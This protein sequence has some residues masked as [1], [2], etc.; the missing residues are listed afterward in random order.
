MA[1]KLSVSLDKVEQ[2]VDL[3]TSLEP[4]PARNYRPIDPSIYIEPDI[5]V[6]KD[7][8]GQYII[9]TNKKGLPTL[10]ISQ[11]YRN[12]LNQAKISKEDRA[13]IKEKVNN[14]LNFIRSLQQRGA[15][16]TAIGKYILERQKNF[17][18]DGDETLAPMT[19]K[20]AAEHLQRNESTIS[21][22]IS[23]KYMDTP[24]GLYPLKF[25]FSH[26]VSRRTDENVS[27]H[28]VEQELA[29]LIEEENKL[30]PLSDQD[31]QKHFDAKGLHLAR[32]TITKYRQKLHIPSSHQRK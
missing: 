9:E 31:I 26:N 10:R 1:K 13:F 4:K 19:L 25:F 29:Q 8:E 15:T 28:T 11:M 24:Q 22:A 21:R 27:A 32:R 2:A 30:F 3:I 16:L 17:F 20:E 6:R 23:N 5:F 14:A 12:L 7:E 18:D